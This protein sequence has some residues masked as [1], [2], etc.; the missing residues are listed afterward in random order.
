MDRKI[1]K[2]EQFGEIAQN[3]DG[4]Y[5]MTDAQ[6]YDNF[7][8]R[9]LENAEESEKTLHWT[10]TDSSARK[11]RKPRKTS[12]LHAARAQTSMSLE[13]MPRKKSLSQVVKASLS[14]KR[15]AMEFAPT[16]KSK[17]FQMHGS[18]K[19]ANW[20]SSPMKSKL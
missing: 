6:L 12:F 17:K 20:L 18:A 1:V 15:C 7:E 5:V 14:V 10:P 3:D 16:R 4:T 2:T 8:K 13:C 19:A 11:S 9:G